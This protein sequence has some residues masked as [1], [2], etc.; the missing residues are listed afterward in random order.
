MFLEEKAWVASD[1]RFATITNGYLSKSKFS[2][3]LESKI[4]K[5]DRVNY[6]LRVLLYVGWSG[7]YL[8]PDRA[9]AQ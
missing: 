5:N 6:I 8:Q 3:I 9:A 4:V 1:Y 2:I 7:K